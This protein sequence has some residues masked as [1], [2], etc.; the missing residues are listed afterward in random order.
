MNK[1]KRSTIDDT[2]SIE[3]RI[4]LTATTTQ[5][6]QTTTSVLPISKTRTSYSARL[7]VMMKRTARYPR[8][9]RDAP[10]KEVRFEAEQDEPN[11]KI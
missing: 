11:R 3:P 5:F 2:T 8:R 10:E 4:V 6:Q 7:R 9:S 1:M